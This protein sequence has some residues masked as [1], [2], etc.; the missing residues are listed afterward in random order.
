MQSPEGKTGIIYCRVSSL[1]QVDGTSLESQEKM[2]NEY[3]KRENIEVKKVFIERGESAK[4]TDRTEFIKAISFCSDKKNRIDCFIVYKVDRFARNQADHTSVRQTLKKYKTELRSVTEPISETPMGKMM[5]G[6]L[7]TFAEF[8]NNI[9]TERSVNG[10]RERIKQ[11]VWVW[12]APLGYK[13]VSRGDNLTPDETYAPFIRMAFEEYATGRHT[14]KSLTEFLNKKGFITRQGGKAIFQLIEKIIKNPIYCGIIRV[15]DLEYK[16]A[17]K[18]LINEDLFYQCQEGGR[19]HKNSPHLVHN[20]EFPLRRLVLCG[21]CKAAMTGSNSKG[22]SRKYPYYHHH[23]QDCT[24]AK[25]IPKESFEQI[26]VEYLN[27][28][29]PNFEYEKA[30]RAIVL[31]IW[32]N[33]F[34]KFD[35]NNEKIRKEIKKLEE[36]RQ[37]IFEFHRTGVYTN[38]E[39]IDQKD[40][41]CRR[42]VQKEALLIDK[43]NQEMNMD[44]AL[45]YCFSFIRQTAK[46]WLEL[47]T[48]PEKRLRFQ[49]LIFADNIEFCEDHFGTAKLTPIYSIYQQYLV[50]PSLLLTLRG[51]EPRLTD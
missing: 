29:N 2:C 50:D 37:R 34:K 17:F 26:F 9:R 48:E 38:A 43:R 7:S 15:W 39:F 51:V 42:I 49:K 46:S 23:K 28:I 14:F 1:E 6:I 16:A 45:D 40:S 5:E 18:P 22:R 41:I 47:K 13:R 24:H 20:A 11:G 21:F 3:A 4:T 25:F 27:E 33:N 36:E 44:E 35:G 30:F 12:R 32:K 8:D 31:D 10:M 19:R